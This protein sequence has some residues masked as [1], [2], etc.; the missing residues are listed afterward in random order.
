MV[1]VFCSLWCH[2]NEF[3]SVLISDHNNV[4]CFL[5]VLHQFWNWILGIGWILEARIFKNFEVSW[6]IW[7]IR[8][9]PSSRF[10]IFSWLL[11]QSPSRILV[12]DITNL[13]DLHSLLDATTQC[14][15]QI[16][17]MYSD[18]NGFWGTGNMALYYMNFKY[19]F[20]PWH[21]SLKFLMQRQSRF[22][23]WMN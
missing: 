8:L 7:S 1:C 15:L 3:K 20:V 11:V 6:G 16:V 10:Y 5:G 2:K 22:S 9:I 4:I 14:W 19:R 18:F 13:Y 12:L 17:L 21:L 23:C